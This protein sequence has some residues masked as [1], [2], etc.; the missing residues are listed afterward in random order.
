MTG[1][2]IIIAGPMRCD[3][4]V[5]QGSELRR[6]GK[7]SAAIRLI[8]AAQDGDTRANCAFQPAGNTRDGA[9]FTAKSGEWIKATQEPDAESLAHVDTLT[10]SVCKSISFEEAHLWGD[11]RALLCSVAGALGRGIHVSLIGVDVDHM[12][13]PFEW[14]PMALNL[15][16]GMVGYGAR[17][18]VYR[19]TATCQCGRRATRTFRHG[20]SNAR[21]LVEEV[22]HYESVCP[23]CG[24]ICDEAR[25]KRDAARPSEP[26]PVVLQTIRPF[27]GGGC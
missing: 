7:T 20:L 27:G 17:A 4:A 9:K 24:A 6:L 1:E 2:L 21:V 22:G 26:E 3:D 5:L 13:E 15:A 12:R 16:A 14:W 10:S 23:V 25:A 8:W 18:D 11:P 19:L